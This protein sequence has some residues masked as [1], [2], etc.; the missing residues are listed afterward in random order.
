MK[1]APRRLSLRGWSMLVLLPLAAAFFWPDGSSRW[2]LMWGI[3]FAFYFGFKWLTWQR[4]N[5]ATSSAG[6]QVAYLAAWPGMDAN[7]FLNADRTVSLPRLFEILIASANVLCGLCLIFDPLDLFKPSP[8]WLYGWS[9]MIGYM[10][11]L[12]FGV[13]RLLSC[14]WRSRGIDAAPI[15]DQPF[16]ATSVASLWGR[17]WN[18]A[19]SDLIHRFWFRPFARKLG[20]AHA[21]WIGFGASGL[22]HEAVMSLPAK[23]GY[24]LPTLY[25]LVQAAGILLER[26]RWGKSVGLGRGVAGWLL[27]MICLIAPL[28]FFMNVPFFENIVIPFFQFMRGDP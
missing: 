3:A 22:I 16:F 18:T 24:G 6:R 28:P 17:R 11:V 13:F 27:A 21:T 15:M 26:S 5:A 2:S 1:V 19:F 9:G 8:S 12:H 4:T 20:L 25:F 23:G 7:A 10:L 14:L